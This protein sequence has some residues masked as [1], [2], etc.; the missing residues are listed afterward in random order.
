MRKHDVMTHALAGDIGKF[1]QH[2][3]LAIIDRKKNMFK[4]SLGEY[5]AAEKI[6]AVRVRVSVCCDDVDIKCDVSVCANAMTGVEAVA[7][8]AERARLRRRNDALHCDGRCVCVCARAL[9]CAR[10]V[11]RARSCDRADVRARMGVRCIHLLQS[12]CCCHTSHNVTHI[13]HAGQSNASLKNATIF[14][15]VESDELK[16]V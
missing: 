15:L 4:T 9:L 7:I 2:G 14:Q 1:S 11:T 13:T 3:T 5:I 12:L 6:E 10:D 8:R 16:K